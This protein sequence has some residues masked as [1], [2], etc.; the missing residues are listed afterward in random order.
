[1]SRF[2]PQLVSLIASRYK[3]ALRKNPLTRHKGRRTGAREQGQTSVGRR[4]CRAL[5]PEVK[6]CEASEAILIRSRSRLAAKSTDV[7]K[8]TCHEVVRT[9]ERIGQ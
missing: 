9:I 3:D 8:G 7:I 4:E 5:T 2:I 6:A 1:M